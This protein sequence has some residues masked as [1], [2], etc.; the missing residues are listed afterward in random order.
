MQNILT[1]ITLSF[2]SFSTVQASIVNWDFQF[3]DESGTQVGNGYLNYDP[4]TTD[5]YTH[6][7]HDEI[8]CGGEDVVSCHYET[9][10]STYESNYF[11]SSYNFNIQGTDWGGGNT[12]WNGS[13]NHYGGAE[14]YGGYNFHPQEGIFLGVNYLSVH[15]LSLGFEDS[16]PEGI[17]HSSGTWVQQ[18]SGSSPPTYGNWTA[19]RT[20]VVPIPSALFLLG[21]GLMSLIM[22]GRKAKRGS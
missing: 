2:I 16:N 21:S 14:R 5:S 18:L 9:I 4:S 6:P 20:S 3:F 17:S 12:W 11:L 7:T 15:Y 10:T 13:A 19:T 22:L 1:I 8:V